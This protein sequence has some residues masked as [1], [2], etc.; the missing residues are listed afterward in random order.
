MDDLSSAVDDVIKVASC[1]AWT[2]LKKFEKE[3][4]ELNSIDE[5]VKFLKQALAEAIAVG[6]RSGQDGGRSFVLEVLHSL[7]G[8]DAF[9]SASRE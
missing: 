7:V 1:G 8:G 2:L 3:N 9:H 5:N 4:P 6:A